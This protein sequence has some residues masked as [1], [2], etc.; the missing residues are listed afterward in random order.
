MMADIKI[1]DDAFAPDTLSIHPG[2]TVTWTLLEGVHTVTSNPGSMSCS[3]SSIESFDSGLMQ[4]GGTTTF[5][6]TFNAAGTFAYHCEVHGCEMKGTVTVIARSRNVGAGKQNEGPAAGGV[7]SPTPRRTTNWFA[8]NN[9]M[10]PGPPSFHI[11]GEVQVPNPGVDVLLTERVPQ[12][13]NPQ[14]ILLDLHL[15]QRPGIW[16]QHVVNK[17]AHFEKL[18]AKYSEATVFMGTSVI[19]D[20]PVVDIL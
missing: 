16:P 12:G 10:P 1:V 11:V 6:H 3:P 5:Q 19:A 14:I 15:V 17:Q 7:L 2:E 9:L 4:S 8:W 18:R 20:V 13:I